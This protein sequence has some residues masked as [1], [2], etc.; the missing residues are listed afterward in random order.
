VSRR[1]I[2]ALFVLYVVAYV[3]R[4]NVSFAALGMRADVGLSDE[5]YGLG[6]GIF[7][8]GYFL[9]EVPSNLAMHRF[10]A[11]V[12]IARI[13]VS[14]GLVSAATMLVRGPASFCVLRFLLGV[15]E[16]GFFPG[17]ILYLTYWF[18]AAQRARAVARFMTAT[19][20]AGVV[21]GPISGA[22]L[23]LGGVAG[24]AGW[25]WLFLLEALPA[26]ALGLAVLVWLPD[27]PPDA[28]WLTPAE[29]DVLVARL[30][31]EAEPARYTLRAALV[32][33]RVWVLGSLYLSLV[34]G[35]YGVSFWLPQ[36]I[37][38]FGDVGTVT[39]GLLS[40]VPYVAAAGGMVVVASRSDR[41]AERRRHVAVA[42]LVGAGGLVAT[43][44]APTAPLALAALSVAAL[45]VWSTLGPFWAVA[46]GFAGGRTGAGAI[47]FVNSLGNL[48]GFVGP[49]LVGILKARTAGFGT[50]LALLS[51]A[52]TV[53]S[54]LA[55]ALPRDT[56]GAA[57]PA[58]E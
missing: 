19:A 40:A 58:S 45:G 33:R 14:W 11:R 27:G 43:A 7:F 32:H 9:F 22:L 3:D 8:V 56:T 52:L 48:G 6:A 17:M 46:T 50:A 20:I 34:T 49:W 31:A 15:A 38:R 41:T 18:P 4:I 42:A 2:P 28:R 10:G 23:A 55:C 24:L 53:A 57:P 35:L 37:Q 25:Q 30:R 1:L 36:L 13:M 26:V 21:G 39:V 47:A 16:A 29:R 51:A 5:A 44:L 54:A 12:W